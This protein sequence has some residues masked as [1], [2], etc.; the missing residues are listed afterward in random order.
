VRGGG[1]SHRRAKVLRKEFREREIPIA[2][3]KYELQNDGSWKV[4]GGR[5]AYQRAKKMK[6]CP[7]N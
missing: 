5:R 2:A 1:V 6:V 4:V 3:V 7:I